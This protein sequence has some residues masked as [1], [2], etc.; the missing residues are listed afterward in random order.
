MLVLGAAAW[1]AWRSAV[2]TPA[3]GTLC[4]LLG[5]IGVGAADSALD[6]P[7]IAVLFW[8]GVLMLLATPARA[9]RPWRRAPAA[10]A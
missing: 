10:H 5:L 3:F 2:A 4:G 6:F 9:A 8:I 7:R 1:G